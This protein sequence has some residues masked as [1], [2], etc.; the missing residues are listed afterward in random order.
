MFD[1]TLERSRSLRLALLSQITLLHFL[2]CVSVL[3]CVAI[4]LVSLGGSTGM[5]TACCAGCEWVESISL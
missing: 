1:L 3:Q 5:G 2:R 4:E